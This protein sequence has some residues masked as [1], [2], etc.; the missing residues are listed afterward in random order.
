MIRLIAFLFLA[1]LFAAA[2]VYGD[3]R[4]NSSQNAAMWAMVAFFGGIAG[5]LVYL[6]LGRDEENDGSGNSDRLSQS[7]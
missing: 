2:F 6:L 4:E 5:V 7:P 1:W 3:A